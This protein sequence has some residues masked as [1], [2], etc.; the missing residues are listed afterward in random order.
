MIKLILIILLVSS[1]VGLIVG[2]LQ[3][4]ISKYFKNKKNSETDV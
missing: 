1:V 2:V 4:K 3:Q